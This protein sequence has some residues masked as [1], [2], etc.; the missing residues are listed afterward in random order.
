MTPVPAPG[1]D[2]I[3]ATL[4]ELIPRLSPDP[5]PRGRPEILPGS[6]LWTGMLVSILRRTGSQQAVWRLLSE[7]GL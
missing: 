4:A 3:E 2:A 6:L 7:A 1:L 5:N